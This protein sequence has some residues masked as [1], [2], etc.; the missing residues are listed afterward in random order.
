MTYNWALDSGRSSPKYISAGPHWLSK[1]H[2][3]VFL[4]RDALPHAF[5]T[6]VRRLPHMYYYP[7]SVPFKL[8]MAKTSKSRGP[9]TVH[10]LADNDSKGVVRPGSTRDGQPILYFP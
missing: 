6:P 10:E 2:S 4:G 3:L 9:N 1:N 8:D 7:Y 5:G